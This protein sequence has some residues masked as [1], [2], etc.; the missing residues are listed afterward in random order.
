MLKLFVTLIV[1][2]LLALAVLGLRHHSTELKA[3]SAHLRDQIRQQENVLR[4]QDPQIAKATNPLVLAERLKKSEQ[5][6]TGIP[7]ASDM[8]LGL[9]P[10]A[11]NTAISADY[12]SSGHQH[13]LV[14]VSSNSVAPGS[15]RHR[16]AQ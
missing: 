11:D 3:Q 9:I 7:P 12:I 5:D 2:L 6:G 1:S 8:P 13:G 4:D 10:Q 15:T 14:T 16:H